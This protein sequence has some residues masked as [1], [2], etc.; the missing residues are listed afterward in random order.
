MMK[1]RMDRF[2]PS[3]ISL[4]WWIITLMDNF[5]LLIRIRWREDLVVGNL[6]R[7]HLSTWVIEIETELDLLKNLNVKHILRLSI[8]EW[9]GCLPIPLHSIQSTGPR[10]YIFHSWELETQHVFI[11]I[12]KE[13]MSNYLLSVCRWEFGRERIRL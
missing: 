9:M 11:K 8:E 2:N 6:H 4:L 13:T 12:R 7:F 10:I 5:C 1:W 3:F